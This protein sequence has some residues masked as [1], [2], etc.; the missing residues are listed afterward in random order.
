MEDIYIEYVINAFSK[1]KD[2]KRVYLQGLISG[3]VVQLIL[4]DQGKRFYNGAVDHILRVNSNQDL[5]YAL[6]QALGPLSKF[7]SSLIV[8]WREW[9]ASYFGL[10]FAELMR[11]E[12]YV[13]ETYK[14]LIL[15][16][17]DESEAMKMTKDI[18]QSRLFELK[19]L[20]YKL[21][22]AN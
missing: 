8:G 21:N 16:K 3:I 1:P 10:W 4:L 18:V 19:A 6:E 11:G 20:L 17:V 15:S 22:L 5:L 9:G 12:I 7:D 2:Y 13:C 14:L